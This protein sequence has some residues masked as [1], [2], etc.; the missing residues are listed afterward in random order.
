MSVSPHFLIKTTQQSV[1]VCSVSS[2]LRHKRSENSFF[3]RNKI[4]TRR[5]WALINKKR[6][7]HL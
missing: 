6:L 2:Y 3:V 1:K 7:E 5:L 4:D